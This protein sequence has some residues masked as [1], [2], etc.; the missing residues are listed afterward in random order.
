MRLNTLLVVI[1][2]LIPLQGMAAETRATIPVT[3]LPGFKAEKI[4][5]VPKAEQGSWVGMT[6]DPK[7]RLITTDQYGGVYRVTVKPEVAVERL[8]I[9]AG[10]AHGALYAFDSLYILTGEGK[11]KGLYRLHDTD[12]DDQYDKEE[13]LISFNSRGEHGVHSLVLSPDGKSIYLVAGNNTDIPDTANKYRMVKKGWSEDHLLPSMPDGRGHNRGRLAP[14]GFIMKLDPE[15]KTQEIICTGFRNEFDAAFNIDGELFSFDADMEWDVGAPWYRPTR[16]NHVVSAAEW[17]W[18]N[19]AGKW[20]SYYTDNLPAV[21]DIGPAS[22]TGVASGLGAKFPAKYQKAIFINDWTYGTMYAI[23][24][25]QDGGTYTATKEE[26]VSGKPLPLTDVMI[27]PDGEMYFMVGGR[28]TQSALYRLE[29]VGKESTAPAKPDKLNPLLSL[30]REL[31]RH[32]RPDA[33]KQGVAAGLKHI[34]H[35]DRFVRWAARVALEHQPPEQWKTAIT[36]NRSSWA[37]IE[38]GTAIA[39]RGAAEDLPAVV[40]ALNRLNY[41]RLSTPQIQAALRS[42]Q[43][44]FIRLGK[45]TDKAAKG[46][47]SKL[48]PLY[49]HSDNYVNRELAQVLLY[50][51]APGAVSSTVQLMLSAADEQTKILD[52][53]VLERN[54]RY[55]AAARRTEQFRPNAQQMSMAFALRSIK[56]GW[57]EAD[58]ASFFSWFPRAKTWQGGNSFGAFVENIRKEALANVE[59]EGQRKKYDELSSKSLEKPRAVVSPKGPGREW[60]LDEAVKVVDKELKEN[61]DFKSGENLFRATACASCHRFAGAGMGIGPDITGAASRYTVRDMLENLIEPSKVISDIYG[62]VEFTM[63]DGSTV[64][65]RIGGE[66]DGKIHLMMNPYSSDITISINAADVKSRKDHELSPM[67]AGLINSLNPD[68]LSDLIAYIFSAGDPEHEYYKSASSS[69][70]EEGMKSLFNGKDLSGW[71][72]NTELWSVKDGAI[73]GSTE[74]QPIKANT[75]LILEGDDIEDFHMI[76]E[77]RVKGNNSGVMYRSEVLDDK[78]FVMKGYQADLHP[79]PEYLAMVYEEKGRGILIK[80]GEK[81]EIDEK[82]N[83]KVLSSEKAEPVD[84]SE[85]QTYEIIAK[86]NH[87]TQKLNGKVAIDLVDR[88]PQR[89]SKGKIGLQLHGGKPMTVEYRN[90]RLKRL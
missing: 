55:A 2:A 54:D 58:R 49:P 51:D 38:L 37:V 88:A 42:Y 64:I 48:S 78:K 47:I 19:G 23:H 22:P 60:T 79:K 21:I 41:Q 61:R 30:R 40:D 6:V 15:A 16:L 86:G 8:N 59:D 74:G 82:G 14:G 76:Y 81:M 9:Q 31:E 67:P 75:F 50:L 45:P 62:N 10:K 90:I 39:R 63:N 89:I 7:G 35:A 83:K 13:K 73:V 77:A 3:T 18:R 25:K 17:G 36:G 29:Y 34:G 11:E 72:G 68:E 87:V 46:V 1:S 56:N 66:E 26:F 28:K 84:C 12:N 69:T 80:R 53:A 32:H 44:A 33:G 4:Y 43:L 57:S 70:S 65:G 27:H 52:D 20:P 5:D 24:L 71:K 85:W